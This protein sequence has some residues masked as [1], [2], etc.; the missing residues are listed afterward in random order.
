MDLGECIVNGLPEYCAG[1]FP[2][3]S[4]HI[5]IYFLGMSSEGST[6]AA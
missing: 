5:L 3:L 1:V 2:A 6:G 4:V